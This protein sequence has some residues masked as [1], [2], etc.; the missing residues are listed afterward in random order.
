MSEIS[1]KKESY[2][3][4]SVKKLLRNKLATIALVVLIIEIIIILGAPLFT[5]YDPAKQSLQERLLPPSLSEQ[6]LVGYDGEPILNKEGEVQYANFHLLGTDNFGRDIWTRIIYGGRISLSVGFAAIALGMTVGVMAGLFS[7]YYPKVDAVVMRIM[8]VMFSFPGI[9]LAMLIVAMLGTSLV[10]VTL[11]IS[12]WSIPTFAR[13]V[14]GE[15]LSVKQND[16]IKAIKSIGAGDLRIIFIHIFPNCIAPIVVYSTMRMATAI[17]S[18]A[19][20]SYL[21]IGAQPPLSE[22]GTMVAAGRDY[23]FDAPHMIVVP[24]VAIII[25]M[26]CFNILGDVLRDILDPN[27]SDNF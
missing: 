10:N 18:I 27:L 19:S 2:F 12:I 26:L 9:L 21:G 20:L 4:N 8:D 22:W 7:A 24:G 16:Y 14:R 5:P 13:I 15:A 25:T 11:A 1:V 6:P 23:M 17:L 3:K